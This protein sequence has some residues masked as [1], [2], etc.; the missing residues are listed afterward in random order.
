MQFCIFEDTASRNFLPLVYFRPVFEL[1]CG[2]LS[3]REKL[4]AVLPKR[5]LT[6]SCREELVPLTREEVPGHPVNLLEETDTWFINGRLLATA[7]LGALVRQR[8]SQEIVYRAGEEI[9]AAFIAKGHA[10]AAV[11]QL[12]AG[13]PFGAGVKEATFEGTLVHYPWDLVHRTSE[14]IRND[15][16]ALTR[17]AKGRSSIRARQPDLRGATLL[18]KKNLIIGEGCRIRPGAVLDGESGPIILGRNVTVMPNAVIE[19]PAFVGDGS[20]I[21]IGAKIYH[22]TAIGPHCKV[23][24][25]VEASVLQSYA[26]KQH[27]GFLG[28]SYLGSWVNLGA[29]TNT[30][31]LKNTYGTIRVMINGTMVET[32][33]QF[34][35]L[36]MGDHSKSGINVMFDTGSVVGASCNIYGATLP[37][38]ALPSFSWFG[39]GTLEEYQLEKG[40]ETA[41]RVMARRSVVMSDAYELLF[42]RVHLSTS[43]ERKMARGG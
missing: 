12:M 37:P 14:E 9:A 15:F 23:G 16:A 31:D 33:Q 39:A 20:V 35:G 29:D 36:T 24:G 28:H 30:S 32:G 5:G 43:G 38:K 26:N 3:L 19:G 2:A 17:M 1:R 6:L 27:E 18:G 7:R 41:R 10:R 25:E 21:K 34:V 8:P 22:G 4:A 13:R 11:G 42:R 40:L